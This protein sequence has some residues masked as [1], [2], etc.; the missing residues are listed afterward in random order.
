MIRGRLR[1]N[2]KNYFAIPRSLLYFD[3]Q[4]LDTLYL[5]A[6]WWNLARSRD[7]KQAKSAAPY[8]NSNSLSKTYDVKKYFATPRCLLYFNGYDSRLLLLIC[9]GYIFMCNLYFRAIQWEER[10]QETCTILN[11]LGY[12][13]LQWFCTETTVYMLTTVLKHKGSTCKVTKVLLR[14]GQTF[15]KVELRLFTLSQLFCWSQT[16]PW[17]YDDYNAISRNY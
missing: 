12:I 9:L 13:S 7:I 3:E 8:L 2:V 10:D 5:R 15:A 1:C 14:R 6:V 11:N 16:S 17:L 4:I